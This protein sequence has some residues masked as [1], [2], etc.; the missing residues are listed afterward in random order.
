LFSTK[1]QDESQA[2]Q[3][4]WQRP[5]PA[6]TPLAPSLY[7]MKANAQ[8]RSL[9]SVPA[10]DMLSSIRVEIDN[11]HETGRYTKSGTKR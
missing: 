10:A 11:R 2:N 3:G 9:P 8:R 6:V 7:H 1:T 5:T 4:E